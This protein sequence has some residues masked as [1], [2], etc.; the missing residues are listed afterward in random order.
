[1]QTCI[2]YT[3]ALTSF[4]QTIPYTYSRVKART[5]GIINFDGKMMAIYSDINYSVCHEGVIKCHDHIFV[6]ARNPSALLTGIIQKQALCLVLGVHYHYQTRNI[7]QI[8][9]NNNSI[10]K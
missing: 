6:I 3:N 10:N 8:T 9:A 2:W 4:V 1:M 5:L 7:M